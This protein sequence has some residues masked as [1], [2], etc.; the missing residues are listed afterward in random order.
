MQLVCGEEY[1]KIQTTENCG[2]RHCLG[3]AVPADHRVSAIGK[4]LCN[5][6]LAHEF[7]KYLGFK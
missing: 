5:G 3:G 2:H 4:G 7:D 6:N 1:A